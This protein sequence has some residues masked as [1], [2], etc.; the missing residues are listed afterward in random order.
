MSIVS[1]AFL[2]AGTLLTMIGGIGVVRFPD[3][4]SRMH[5]AAKAP[6]LGLLL[7]AIGAAIQIRTA[8]AIAT[9]VLVV[10]LQLLTSPVATHMLGRASHGQVDIPV[11]HG[12]ALAE[13][14]ASERHDLRGAPGDADRHTDDPT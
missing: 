8:H 11:D 9:L 14:L 2:I 10:I 1:G 13:H 6:T 4:M 5:A 3:L 7:I 12:D